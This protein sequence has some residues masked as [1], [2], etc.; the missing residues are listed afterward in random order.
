M[1]KFFIFCIFSIGI[2]H[3]ILA[4]VSIN[5]NGKAPDSSAM[6]D[7]TSTNKGFLPPR[8]SHAAILAI[9]SPAVGL[10]VYDSTLKKTV[11]FN[12]TE[13]SFYD[14]CNSCKSVSAEAKGARADYNP[15]TGTGT[16]NSDAIQRAIEEVRAAGGGKVFLPPG[17]LKITKPILTY[18]DIAIIGCGKNLTQIFKM[19]STASTIGGIDAPGRNL[20][21]NY[22][23]N[24]FISIVH[25]VNQ[26]AYDS[27]I[28]GIGFIGEPANQQDIGIY[29]PR[30]S[31]LDISD[32]YV[33]N[34][35]KGFLTYDSWFGKIENALFEANDYGV[36]FENDGAGQGTGT[37][38]SITNVW[39]IDSKIKGYHIYGLSYSSF[40]NVACDGFNR[41]G[42]NISQ[43]WGAAAYAFHV[44]HNIT[45][46]GIGFEE[47]R[48]TALFLDNS[49]VDVSGGYGLNMRGFNNSFFS[50]FI[51]LTDGASLK[52]TNV[53]FPEITENRS[54]FWNVVV[55]TDSRL[56]AENTDL[57]SGSGPAPH[58]KGIIVQN[59]GE[60]I[61]NS[62]FF[63]RDGKVMRVVLEPVK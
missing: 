43:T 41:T 39:A 17:K 23:V 35:K 6:L 36:S 19:G 31:R 59:R 5:N 38:M 13:W 14:A 55:Q 15:A 7:I 63:N 10:T 29:A 2:S 25:P 54:N 18:P 30:T 32:V 33:V 53:H 57:P 62:T 11:F 21:D 3:S 56:I 27:K 50:G 12:G 61:E 52:I 26:F 47:S 24:S 58:L 1:F 51:F 16:D 37:S 34:T 49:S 20:D 45:I 9:K 8:M 60:I 44:C 42:A 46:Q 4:Q 40:R 48:G 22:N 28:T